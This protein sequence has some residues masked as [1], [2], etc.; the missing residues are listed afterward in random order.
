ML[1]TKSRMLTS[2]I[3]CNNVDL[4][5][6]NLE[7]FLFENKTKQVSQWLYYLPKPYVDIKVQNLLHKLA[8]DPL[9]SAKLL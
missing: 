5:Y 3:W 1:M 6:L 4:L 8:C 9:S 2:M 7:R